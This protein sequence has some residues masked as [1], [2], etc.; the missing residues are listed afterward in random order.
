MIDEQKFIDQLCYTWSTIGIDSTGAGSQVRAASQGLSKPTPYRMKKLEPFESYKLPSDVDPRFLPIG[1]AP[2][3]LSLFLVDGE[4]VL[5]QKVYAGKDGL[6]RQGAFFAHFFMGLP[7]AFS[8]LDAIKLWQSPVFLRSESQLDPHSTELPPVPVS[9]LLEN[10]QNIQLSEATLEKAKT[11][12]PYIMQAYLTKKP[13]FKRNSTSLTKQPLYIVADDEDIAYFIFGLI[14]CLPPQL[15]RD[16]TFSTYEHNFAEPLIEIIGTSWPAGFAKDQHAKNPFPPQYYQRGG[17]LIMNC[18][19]ELWSPLEENPLVAHDP[20]ATDFSN[21]ALAYLVEGHVPDFDFA[22]FLVWA[23]SHEHLDVPMFLDLYDRWKRPFTP[24]AGLSF[25]ELKDIE[26]VESFLKRPIPLTNRYIEVANSLSRLYKNSNVSREI[27]T[28]LSLQLSG[29]YTD[30]IENGTQL[31]SVISAMKNTFLTPLELFQFLYTMASNVH[32]GVKERRY[33]HDLILVYYELTFTFKTVFFEPLF[34]ATLENSFVE[35][36]S[37]ILL[38][39]MDDATFN[40]FT[41]EAT[42]W[43][44]IVGRWRSYESSLDSTPHQSFSVRSFAYLP[45]RSEELD[46]E[47]RVAFTALK[48]ALAKGKVER[49]KLVM[50]DHRAVF[51]DH[52]GE[53]PLEWWNTINAALEFSEACEEADDEKRDGTK[54]QWET[55]ILK[56]YE[57]ICHLPEMRCPPLNLTA[58][59]KK[60]YNAARDYLATLDKMREDQG[61]QP[62]MMQPVQTIVPISSEIHPIQQKPSANIFIR[63]FRWFWS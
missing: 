3:C 6:G 49:I 15:V 28:R 45:V 62:R 4:R 53:I 55:A 34:T 48:K 59:E 9:T 33:P 39:D 58:Y 18:Y 14:Y 29:A 19:A 1:R 30:C 22:Q 24:S 23:G 35:N 17:K 50:T 41:S 42:Y 38:D 31:V 44:E 40:W 27:T 10:R 5:A 46:K 63:L 32:N 16:I 8:P 37:T 51:S 54:E 52:D 21:D 20:R 26:V 2:I 60:R 13:I 61:Q 43:N 11:H 57:N 56:A 47:R 36:I 25:R 7:E 12:F